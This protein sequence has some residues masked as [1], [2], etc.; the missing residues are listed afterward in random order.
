MRI[1]K[2]SD[3]G[4]VSGIGDGNFRGIICGEG[5]GGGLGGSTKLSQS[6]LQVCVV[7][8]RKSGHLLCSKEMDC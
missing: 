4:D 2:S 1:P 8:L 5:D 3:V 7:L 6:Y